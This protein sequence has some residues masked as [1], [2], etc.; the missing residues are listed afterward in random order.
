MISKEAIKNNI[1][2]ILAITEK[3]IKL[4]LRFKYKLIFSFISPIISIILPLIIMGKFFEFNDNFGPW[5]SNN[6]IVYIFLAYNIMQLQKIINRYQLQFSQEKFWQTLPG[7]LIAPFNTYYLLIGIFLSYL[8]LI[9]IPLIIFFIICF[10]FFP[11]SF[12]TVLSIIF[13]TLLIALIFSGLGLIL[14]IFAISNENVSPILGFGLGLIFMASCLSFPF[15]IFPLFIQNIINLNPLYH[16]FHFYRLVWIED[17]I[18]FSI[19]SHLV[20]FLVLIGSAIILPYIGVIIFNK[21][22]KKYGIV[23]Y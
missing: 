16:I 4:R 3:D 12:F 23:G 22:Y 10:V 11:I 1:S 6:Y 9:S 2:Q 7:L 18:I 20:S 5:D 21:I 17:N 13:I 8:I 19:S 14:G 15:E